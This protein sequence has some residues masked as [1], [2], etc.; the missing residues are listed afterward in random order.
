M[1]EI[2]LLIHTHSDYHYL[3]PI[4]RDY[5]QKIPIKKVLA[6][7][8]I[9][10]GTELP[11]YFDRYV[12]YDGNMCYAQRMH[13]ILANLT[14][15]YVFLVHDIDIILNIDINALKAYLDIIIENDIDRV[16]MSVFNGTG[17]IHKSNYVLCD[18]NKPLLTASNQFVPIDCQP[19]I[20]KRSSFM[21]LLA[22]FPNE[23]YASLELTKDVINYCINNFKCYGVQ[24][25]TNLKIKY[26]RA[27]TMCD[28]FLFLHI[29][30]KG[31]FTY[32]LETYMDLK[33]NLEEIVRKYSI[34][35]AKIGTCNC[36]FVLRLPKPF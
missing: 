18:L 7:N 22:L 9:P 12:K 20:W 35:V 21:K 3:W 1:E 32:P 14:S 6:Y 13:E 34:D 28:L 31:K 27:L 15:M 11:K 33:P 36:E 23:T 26:N 16:H 17:K 2:S 5:T 19:A 30:T 25:T 4:I 29:T 24:Y 8:S 10:E